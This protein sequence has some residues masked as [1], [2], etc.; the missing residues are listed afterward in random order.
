MQPFQEHRPGLGIMVE[1][2]DGAVAIPLP[3]SY[4]F[5]DGLVRNRLQF[6]GSALTVR[7]GHWKN[8]RHHTVRWLSVQAETPALQ[9]GVRQR[10]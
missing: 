1:K 5:V 10:G 7:F 8:Q 2:T 4:R 9:V 6:Q 3:E